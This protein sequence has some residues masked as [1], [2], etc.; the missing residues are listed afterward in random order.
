[1]QFAS[2]EVVAAIHVREA[3]QIVALFYEWGQ[4]DRSHRK[5]AHRGSYLE[6]VMVSPSSVRNVFAEQGLWLRALPRPGCSTRKAFPDWAEQKPEGRG[7]AG[8]GLPALFMVYDGSDITVRPGTEDNQAPSI[9][10]TSAVPGDAVALGEG[11]PGAGSPNGTGFAVNV[12]LTT[13]DAAAP[14]VSEGLNIRHTDQLGL[15]NPD[16]PG[17]VVTVDTN[18]TKPE[19]GIIAKGTNLAS[20][21]N[22]AGTDDTPGDGVT[23]WAGWHVLESLAPGTKRLTVTATVTDTAGR[24][25]RTQ[26]VYDVTGAANSGQALTPVPSAQPVRSST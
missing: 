7:P 21:F 19:G 22:V 15:P 11:R 3:E 23:V 4:T 14:A 17:L 16:F 18:L 9:A 13:H 8:A 5:L 2:G 25:A 10:L 12:K 20:L 24:R 6:R 26:Q 1:M